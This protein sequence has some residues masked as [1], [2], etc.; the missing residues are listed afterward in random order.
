MQSKLNQKTN[1]LAITTAGV[2]A[3]VGLAYAAI[4]SSDGVIHS[5]YN[6]G[7]NSSGQLRVVDSEAGAKCA[8]NEKVL[9]FNQKGPKGD[10]GDKGD[11]CLSSDPACVGPRG[12]AGKD[13]ADGTAGLNGKDGVDG[14]DGAPGPAG[15]T[16]D[17]WVAAVG[18]VNITTD[19]M[20]LQKAVPA[21]NYIISFVATL[22]NGDSDS[23]TTGCRLINN[24]DETLVRLDGSTSASEEESYLQDINIETALRAGQPTTLQ[25][26]CGGYGVAVRRAV[27]TARTVGTIH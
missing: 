13:G 15:A 7:S 18:F 14:K 16:S 19:R 3:T 17:A 26:N 10:K 21:G 25:I 9:D 20:V 11:A 2:L 24:G 1:I 27:L 5:C 8:K 23:Q 12:P 6:A 4:P 22:F